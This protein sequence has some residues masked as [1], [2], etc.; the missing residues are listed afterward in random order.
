[1]IRRCVQIRRRRRTAALLLCWGCVAMFCWSCAPAASAAEPMG[2]LGTALQNA[3]SQPYQ[4]PRMAA[5][6]PVQKAV[7]RTPPLHRTERGAAAPAR[8]PAALASVPVPERSQAPRPPLSSPQ[9]PPS[10]ARSPAPAGGSLPAVLPG[11]STSAIPERDITLAQVVERAARLQPGVV[12]AEQ[13][14]KQARA[15]ILAAYTPFLP[16]ISLQAQAQDY[17]NQ[18]GK[19]ALT[20]VGSTL[21]ATQGSI[22]S[23]YVSLMGSLNIFS[24]GQDVAGMEAAEA[25]YRAAG[26]SLLES[27]DAAVIDAMLAFTDL[28]TAQVELTRQEQIVQLMRD[29]LSLIEARYRRGMASLIMVDQAQADANRASQDLVHAR[30]KVQEK[31]AILAERIALSIPPDACLH[32]VGSLPE[33]PAVG[34][35]DLQAALDRLPSVRRAAAEVKAAEADLRK[36]RGGF[37]PTVSLQASYNWLGTA[38]S[39][40]GSAFGGTAAN[41]YTVGINIAQPLLPMTSQVAAVQDARAALISAHT[42]Y[43]EA[44]LKAQTL[45][46]RV[47]AELEAGRQAWEL[48]GQSV[49]S[50]RRSLTLTRALFARGRASREDVNRAR[51]ALIL[52]ESGADNLHYQ[53]LTASWAAYRLVHPQGF[54]TVLSRQTEAPQPGT[55]KGPQP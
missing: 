28:S 50:A 11:P 48:A 5:A 55:G 41:N 34:P 8:K 38:P 23:N 18:S 12:V 4:P 3:L 54:L 47:A 15:R 46:S 7:E 14:I 33:A 52:A 43:E 24:G 6:A 44:M 35:E 22:Y 36:A 21:V 19:P 2:D 51:S 53:Y 27:R 49:R 13:T 17:Q 40:I 39:S 30:E 32:A 25:R 9:R 45:A 29:G 10:P 26:A 16:Q 20:V 37:F 42:R 1:M 31:A